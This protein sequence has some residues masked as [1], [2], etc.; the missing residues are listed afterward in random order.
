MNKYKGSYK[1]FF[2]R[3]KFAQGVKANRSQKDFWL[4]KQYTD[5]TKAR[6]VPPKVCGLAFKGWSYPPLPKPKVYSMPQGARHP[7][8]FRVHKVHKHIFNGSRFG[9][10]KIR[11]R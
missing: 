1:P 3:P 5:A 8:E 10:R 7:R 4:P 9:P 2:S 11:L 6:Y